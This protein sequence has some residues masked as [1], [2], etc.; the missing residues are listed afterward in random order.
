MLSGINA[1]QLLRMLGDALEKEAVAWQPHLYNVKD[2]KREEIGA[3]QRDGV[4]SWLARI[5]H[6]FDFNLETLALGTALLD[7]FLLSV[8]ARPKYLQCIGIACFYLAAKTLEEDDVVPGTQEL[9]EKSH[10]E[11]SVSEVLRMERV[12]LDKFNWDLRMTTPLDFLNIFYALL[13]YN[14]P[15]LLDGCTTLTAEQHLSLLSC[16]LQL[17]LARH[18]VLTF[19][20]STLALAVLSLELEMFRPDWLSITLILQRMAH[21]SSD[22]LIHC[23]ETIAHLMTSVNRRHRPVTMVT[24]PA[25]TNAPKSAK[26]KVDDMD[27]D[28]YDGIKRKVDDADDDIY[29]GIKQLY[30]EDITD[31]VV[32][33]VAMTKCRSQ[34]RQD[35]N[36]P[37]PLQAVAN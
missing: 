2:D 36:A 16:K 34:I 35:A 12:V 8:K 7:K 23:R 19:R 24:A 31:Q 3:E 17:C 10:C 15:A 28:V 4:V 22:S 13:L 6:Q 25:I 20:P 29:D 21:I 27:D 37:T 26:R 30:N 33:V 18:P 32:T 5:N 1:Q 9:L 14:F 11:R